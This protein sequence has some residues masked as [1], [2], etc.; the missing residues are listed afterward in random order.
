MAEPGLDYE[1]LRYIGVNPKG[2]KEHQRFYLPF[3]AQCRMVVD[4]GCGDGDFVELLDA[5]G[6][7]GVGVDADPLV[8]KAAQER[9]IDVVCQDVFD[10]LRETP[11]ESVDGF[12]SSHL[13]EH[14]PYER[15][16][17]LMQLCYDALRPQGV[18]VLTMPNVRALT[19]HLEQFYLHFGHVSF[20]HP[21]LLS[22]FLEHVGFEDVEIGEN[23]SKSSPDS[24][25]F[26]GLRLRPIQV[27][28][29]ELRTSWF[30][31]V[32]RRVRIAFARFFLQPYLGL[33]DQNF[34]RIRESLLR[35]DRPFECYAKGVKPQRLD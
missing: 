8:C 27:R 2:Q 18:L 21:R 22:F 17:E 20:Y 1:F 35:I 13:V 31:R 24:P 5:E 30:Q 11:V 9:G 34:A 32:V 7:E 23:A 6:I 12:F 10:Y 4:L 29:P 33:I 19:S 25:L 14:L 16:L 3:F 26:D 15:V 28:L